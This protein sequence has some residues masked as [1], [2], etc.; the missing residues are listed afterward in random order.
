[1]KKTTL[2]KLQN[3]ETTPILLINYLDPGYIQHS[4]AT[5]KEGYLTDAV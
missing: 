4:Y 3:R 2:F 1:M 5:D